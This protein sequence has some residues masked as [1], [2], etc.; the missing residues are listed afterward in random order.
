MNLIVFFIGPR[1]DIMSEVNKIDKS[2]LRHEIKTSFKYKKFVY[3]NKI[4]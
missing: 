4:I 2:R 1:K 3:S